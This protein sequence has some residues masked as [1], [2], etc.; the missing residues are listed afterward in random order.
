MPLRDIDTA[1]PNGSHSIFFYE[2]ESALLDNLSE[3]GGAALGSGGSCIVI[4][5][6]KHRQQ[7]ADCLRARGVNVDLA[8][9]R[10]R[11]I[12]LDA[13]KTL[14]KFLVEG[15][16]DSE[17]FFDVLEPEVRRAGLGSIRKSK[18]IVGF[19]EMVALFWKKGRNE[20]T[21]EVER[22]RAELAHSNNTTLR[23]ACPLGSFKNES[24]LERFRKVCAEHGHVVPAESYTSDRKS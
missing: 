17:L 4:A 16:P 24:Q 11:Y 9:S 6:K 10:N 18:I 23:C 5:T 7:L 12:E 14:S 8:T 3:F 20:Y 1:E 22:L 19:I 2:D 13:E 21:I 15:W